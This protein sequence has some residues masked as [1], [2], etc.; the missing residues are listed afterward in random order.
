MRRVPRAP[1]V[2]S[3]PVVVLA[4]AASSARA[5]NPGAISGVH[6][7][8]DNFVSLSLGVAPESFPATRARTRAARIGSR[9]W[10]FRSGALIGPWLV[11]A[12]AS[13]DDVPLGQGAGV[14][15]V[16]TGTFNWNVEIARTDT[17]PEDRGDALAGLG[18]RRANWFVST[19]VSWR[20]WHGHVLRR[21]SR[22]STASSTTRGRSATCGPS[23]RGRRAR[24]SA[25]SRPSSDVSDASN[26]RDHFGIT[27]EQVLTRAQLV[28]SGDP[29]P[30]RPTSG[31]TSPAQASAAPTRR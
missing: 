12:G 7:H 27:P 13:R 10:T 26:L 31:R 6:G 28:A 8:S 30:L 22:S 3:L 2:L 9:S 21:T 24:G 5:D 14:Y 15:P 25:R 23:C 4:L 16:H 11:Y 29:S 19:R 1:G 18:D 20:F 17:R